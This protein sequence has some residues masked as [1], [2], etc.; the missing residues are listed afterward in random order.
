MAGLWAGAVQALPLDSLF[1]LGGTDTS[2]IGISANRETG[3]GVYRFLAATHDSLGGGSWKVLDTV[4]SRSTEQGIWAGEGHLATVWSRDS[5]DLL[6]RL[7]G[8]TGG[9]GAP[10]PSIAEHAWL[11]MGLARWKLPEWMGIRSA[12]AGGGIAERQDPGSAS[13]GLDPGAGSTPTPGST[14]AAL[15]GA[16]VGWASPWSLPAELQGHVLEDQGEGA[17]R[18]SRRS[19]T[20]SAAMSVSGEGADTLRAWAGWDSLRLRSMHLLVDRSEGSRGVGL[21][22]TLFAGRQVWVAD[23][24]WSG[25]GKR[26]ETGRSQGQDLAGWYG[27]IEVQ[28]AL[29]RGW[30]HH[31]RLSWS[32]EDRSFRT[33]P[34]GEPVEDSLQAIQDGKEGDVVRLLQ[35]SDTLRWSTE[36]GGGWAVWV[37][38]VQALR[39]VRHPGNPSPSAFDR[40]DEDLSRRSLTFSVTNRDWGCPDRPL[41]SWT[42]LVQDDVFPRA[43]Q[44]INTNHRVE[45]RMSVDVDPSFL[46]LARWSGADSGRLRPTGGIWGREQRNRW[47]FDSA[48][49]EGLLEE[50]WW[51]G[52]EAG[53]KSK[54]WILAK[55][56]RW[57]TWTGSLSGEDFAP[58]RIQDD[59]SAE[60]SGTIPL[61]MDDSLSLSPWARNQVERIGAWDGSDWVQLIRSRSS[62]IGMDLS[63]AWGSGRLRI[64]GGWEWSEPG[65]E[66][67]VGNLS[68]QSWW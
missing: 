2:R 25:S 68:M 53:P 51:A 61:P 35:L 38:A 12:V 3:R 57:R 47:R 60:L 63:W 22:W 55:W 27:D 52:L 6:W 39:Q 9:L 62:R 33:L 14:G 30:S 64:G 13:F 26:D 65:W 59:W 21:S 4:L 28:G 66:G 8:R 41:A 67:W 40:P 56:R 54:P 16:E 29:G 48:R 11:Q 58:D 37:G 7:W 34:A 50:G 10:D 17:L 36:E 32:R 19:V 44:S 20:A 46:D 45:N 49:T 5:L 42:G 23:G 24:S 18:L 31:Q 15:W 43:S 1:V